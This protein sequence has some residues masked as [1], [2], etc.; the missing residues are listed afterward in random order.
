MSP[1]ERA[2]I[3]EAGLTGMSERLGV[4]WRSLMYTI[5]GLRSKLSVLLARN[6]S[7]QRE[8]QDLKARLEQKPQPSSKHLGQDLNRPGGDSN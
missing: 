3:R 6:E 8:V 5:G 7:L 2:L 1:K 4:E